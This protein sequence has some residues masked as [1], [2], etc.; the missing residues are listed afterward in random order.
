M[1][2]A[3]FLTSITAFVV[4]A[5]AHATFQDL[6]VN[7]KDQQSTCA[8]LPM[9]NSPVQD[10]TSKDIRCRYLLTNNR[11]L[12][13][14]RSSRQCKSR[15][16]CFQVQCGAWRHCDHRDAPTEQRSIMRERGDWGSPL[17]CVYMHVVLE[18]K[19]L[20]LRLLDRPGARL[21]FQSY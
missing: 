5:R 2:G 15:P 1:R 19:T 4:T 16:C 11:I 18:R 12:T 10:V 21:P 9:S 8:R 3:V 14:T 7:G 6:W 13:L 20:T 17:W